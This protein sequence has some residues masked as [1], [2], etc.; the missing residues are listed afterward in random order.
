MKMEMVMVLLVMVMVLVLLHSTIS[1]W[2]NTLL[3]QP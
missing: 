3:L 1:E 2:G